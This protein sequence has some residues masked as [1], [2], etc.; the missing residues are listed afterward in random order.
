M[1][2]EPIKYKYKYKYKYKLYYKYKYVP[3]LSR[4]EQCDPYV[5]KF[6]AMFL[7]SE[8]QALWSL[9]CQMLALCWS[10]TILAMLSYQYGQKSKQG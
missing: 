2:K 7:D 9:F 5:Q 4:G 10:N 3:P 6:K 1:I 8:D